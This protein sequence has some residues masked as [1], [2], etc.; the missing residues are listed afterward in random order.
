MTKLET[1]KAT[2]AEFK[3]GMQ[4]GHPWLPGLAFINNPGLDLHIVA[5]LES[6][7]HKLEVEEQV[8]PAKRVSLTEE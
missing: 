2:Q 5:A 6:Y 3:R 4:D 7:V 8:K 1:A